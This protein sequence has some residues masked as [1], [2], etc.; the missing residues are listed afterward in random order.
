MNNKP[1]IEDIIYNLLLLTFISLIMITNIITGKYFKFFDIPLTS[2]ILTYPFTF[3]ITDIV[4]EI[5]G[6]RKT[7]YLIWMGFCA[8][9]LMIVVIQFVSILPIHKLS[10]AS[11]NDFNMVFKLT[12]GITIA[13]LLAYLISQFTD[14]FLYN[15]IKILTKGKK[16]WIRNNLATMVSQLIDTIVFAVVAFTF[17]KFMNPDISLKIKTCLWFKIAFYEYLIKCLLALLDTPILYLSLSMI[18]YK[19]NSNTKKKL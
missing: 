16:I 8:N 6:A 9:I 5:Y 10:P 12:P 15:K 11:D 3:L 1:K 13:S 18:K 2:G 4:T 7:K 14:V 17:W 19:I